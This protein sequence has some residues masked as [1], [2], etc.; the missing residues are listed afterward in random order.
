MTTINGNGAAAPNVPDTY[1]GSNGKTYK[2]IDYE[3]EDR[4]GHVKRGTILTGTEFLACASWGLT[5]WRG[6]SMV[7]VHTSK[8]PFKVSDEEAPEALK[9]EFAEAAQQLKL[10]EGL[11][12]KALEV[13]DT[14]LREIEKIQRMLGGRGVN[15]RGYTHVSELQVA[16][17]SAERDWRQAVDMCDE[18]RRE[19]IAAQNKLSQWKRREYQKR[20]SDAQEAERVRSAAPKF[21]LRDRI[22]AALQL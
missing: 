4:P 22:A 10:A 15:E 1:T 8:D 20:Q 9:A 16:E 19:F 13:W 5:S 3:A 18:A 7:L 6:N 11:S 2:R 17:R 21:S 12:A 14:A